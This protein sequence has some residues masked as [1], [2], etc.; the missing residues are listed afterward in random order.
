M[1]TAS[2]ASAVTATRLQHRTPPSRPPTHPRRHAS[3]SEGSQNQPYATGFHR[4]QA[5]TTTFHPCLE[6]VAPSGVR[7]LLPVCQLLEHSP[8]ITRLVSRP[9]S[10]RMGPI[11][12]S[13]PT[14]SW[15]RK[16]VSTGPLQPSPATPQATS[17]SPTCMLLSDQA[18]TSPK[19][20]SRCGLF[21]PR[22]SCSSSTRRRHGTVP[23]AREMFRCR[24]LASSSSSGQDWCE[25]RQARC[26]KRSCCRS[27]GSRRMLGA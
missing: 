21:L 4:P 27:T 22:T 3:C 24:M 17:P 20:T 16:T 10:R 8:T 2:Y 1:T 12:S 26:S 14:S 23:S 18:W 5:I 13:A 19:R 9:L 7:N 11:S 25:Q 6:V 15:P